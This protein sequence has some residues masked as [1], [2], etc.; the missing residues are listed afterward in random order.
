MSGVVHQISVSPGGVPKLPVDGPV[1]VH[2]SGVTGDNQADEKHHGGPEQHVCLYSLEV[3]AALQAEG[4]P[5]FPGAA[6]ENITVAGL[7]WE[8]VA[9]GQRMSI[10]DEVVLEITWPATPCAK[11]AQWF[12]DRNP[13]RMSHELHPGWSRWYASVV[14]PGEIRVG[15]TATLELPHE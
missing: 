9:R 6:G 2:E 15:D 3:I 12:S 8:A 14:K 10:G 7:E 11:N 4:H 13:S 5:I 1:L